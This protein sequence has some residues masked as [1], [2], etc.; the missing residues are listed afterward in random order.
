MNYSYFEL[1]YSNFEL[2]KVYYPVMANGI[3][4]FE[5]LQ[6]LSQKFRR[7]YINAKSILEQLKWT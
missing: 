3:R 2:E 7:I 5:V 4:N 6:S 1:N